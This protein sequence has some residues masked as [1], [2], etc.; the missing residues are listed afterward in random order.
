MRRFHV[1]RPLM[2]RRWRREWELHSRDFSNCH[3]GRGIGTMR[4]HKPLESHP[5]S[6]CGVCAEHRLLSRLERRRRRYEACRV[7]EEGLSRA[8]ESTQWPQVR[9][10]D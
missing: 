5:S 6:S 4:K 8:L 3:C 2:I 9:D 10:H 1:E 7:I